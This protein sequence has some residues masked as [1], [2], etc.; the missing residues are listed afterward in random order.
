M[1]RLCVVSRD[2][3]TLPGYLMVVLDKEIKGPEGLDLIFDRRHPAAGQNGHGGRAE[4]R[5]APGI[6]EALRTRGYVIV[7]EDDATPPRSRARRIRRPAIPSVLRV[8]RRAIATAVV[9]L[10]VIT[11]AAA[12]TKALLSISAEERERMLARAAAWVRVGPDTA[13]APERGKT[14]STVD[15]RPAS[16]PTA[17][18]TAMKASPF[19]PVPDRSRGESTAPAPSTLASSPSE[20][21][22][23]ASPGT[24]QDEGS[25]QAPAARTESTPRQD[26][27]TTARSDSAARADATARAESA[28]RTGSAA[29]RA[30]SAAS[31]D[32]GPRPQSSA[33]PEPSARPDLPA[34]PDPP[35]RREAVARSEAPTLP[36]SR[37]EPGPSP[38]S[39]SGRPE[40]P[41][42]SAPSARR[43]ATPIASSA[44]GA[45][46]P[47]QA[48]PATTRRSA[49]AQP[50]SPPA[51]TPR[52]AGPPR[53]ELVARPE[54]ADA[55]RA[56]TYTVRI[57]DGGG[58]PVANARVT[59]HGWMPNGSDIVTA[60]GSTTTPG[61]YSGTATVGPATPGNLR[62]RV[63]Y[64]GASFEIPSGR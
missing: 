5:Q 10:A 14:P 61:T 26:P 35:A 64:D 23:S 63:K 9:V 41:D 31:A 29:A 3:P 46:E 11:G 49:A 15:P 42:S 16:T 54:G 17:R 56:I 22:R 2:A 60:L 12:A 8:S 7:G 21:T 48:P 62:V 18:S 25:R 44:R 40:V 30:D 58:R 4:R 27:A 13:T 33:R 53:V 55:S 51:G 32:S 57:R 1:G 59:L 38:L 52:A 19:A 43:D 24:R 47:A 39:A 45:G 50:E 37:R 34:L 36:P 6:D 28:A 20:A